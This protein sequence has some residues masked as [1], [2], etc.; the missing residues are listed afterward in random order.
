[1][2]ECLCDKC[3]GRPKAIDLMGPS[4]HSHLIFSRAARQ[5]SSFP[6]RRRNISEKEEEHRRSREERRGR[7]WMAGYRQRERKPEKKSLSRFTINDW[8]FLLREGR[9]R[10]RESRELGTVTAK[11]GAVET[12][13]HFLNHC[14]PYE[15]IRNEYFT[16]I[17]QIVPKFP[18]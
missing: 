7:A 12:A 17:T 3:A 9:K 4:S 1:M 10:E 16:E 18:C 14:Q 11:Q 13:L 5:F 15:N 2:C 8:S 6:Y